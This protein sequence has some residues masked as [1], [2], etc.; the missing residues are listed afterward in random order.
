MS[1][2]LQRNLDL[3]IPRKGIAR[4]LSPNIHIY[5]SVSD[6]YI[7]PRSVH[8]F[9]CSRIDR[10]ISGIYKSLTEILYE[11]TR[12][13]WGLWPRSSFSGNNCFEFSVLCLCS[14]LAM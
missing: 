6:L 11:C 14:V 13:I 8:L 3:C 4:C 1:T 9:S 12:R 7:F 5:V 10:P 2:A